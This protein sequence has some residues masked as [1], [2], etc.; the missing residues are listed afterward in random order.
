M[1]HFFCL[2]I[3]LLGFIVVKGQV[4]RKSSGYV[5]INIGTSYLLN[6][7]PS[8]IDVGANLNL[9]NAGYSFSNN[10]GITLKW[11]GG[12][13]IFSS[14]MEIGYGAILIGPMYSF[15]ILDRTFLDLKFA[16]GMFW[17]EEKTMYRP[18]DPNDP[19]LSVNFVQRTKT[20]RI[21]NF[22]AG[23]ALRHNIG[24]HWTLLLLAEYNAGKH[25]SFGL[26]EGDHLKVLNFN[27]GVGFRF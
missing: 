21:A 17:T 22:A 20:I 12:A 8:G 2:A 26:I 16:S 3:T 9:I 13:H 15:L 25:S 27:A 4:E 23:L 24:N 19:L 14:D 6:K 1:K 11:M 7:N 18:T 10:M 5:G